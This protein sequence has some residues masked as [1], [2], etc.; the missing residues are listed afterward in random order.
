[1]NEAGSNTTFLNATAQGITTKDAY[2]DKDNIIIGNQ[3]TISGTATAGQTTAT[4]NNDVFADAFGSGILIRYT[5]LSIG[6]NNYIISNANGG[7]SNSTSTAHSN[8]EA[9]G[10]LAMDCGLNIANSNQIIA[11]AT[12]GASQSTNS[13]YAIAN[14][15]GVSTSSSDSTIG[16]DNIIKSN[17]YGGTISGNPLNA[18]TTTNA[19]GVKVDTG[20]FTVA[21]SQTT[22]DVGAKAGTMNDASQAYG[23]W[24]T[25]TSWMDGTII[26]DYATTP[27]SF[28]IN[29]GTSSSIAYIG[30]FG[31][32]KKQIS[33][34]GAYETIT[35]PNELL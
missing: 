7:L 24:V 12:A 14:S 13:A 1:M 16:N 34:G 26:F 2:G 23:L 20:N 21:G 28:D 17:S 31:Y 32:I 6:N 33:L 19:Y 25:G 30:S 15:S 8:A 11:T 10:L 29:A 18:E 27:N 4:I 35:N 3:N 5:N 22:L 9:N